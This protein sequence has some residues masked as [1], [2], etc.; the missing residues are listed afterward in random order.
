MLATEYM[1]KMSLTYFLCQKH[2]N[3]KKYE[4]VT[5]IPSS[6]SIIVFERNVEIHVSSDQD[7]Q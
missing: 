5:N 6:H 1:H 4:D 7:R 2:L 3:G